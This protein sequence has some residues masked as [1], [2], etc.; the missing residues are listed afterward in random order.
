MCFTNSWILPTFFM[1]TSILKMWRL[2]T[3]GSAGEMSIMGFFGGGQSAKS[4]FSHL[5]TLGR[6]MGYWWQWR[7]K[8]SALS[9]CQK[10]RNTATELFCV[11]CS[12]SCLGIVSNLSAFIPKIIA[13]GECDQLDNTFSWLFLIE[14]NIIY[15][16]TNTAN[17][18]MNFFPQMKGYHFDAAKLL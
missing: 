13:R 10:L 17:K 4:I 12:L 9:E 6:L 16:D 2:M 18:S 1:L 15:N 14:Q 8:M 11:F 5:Y 3:C 7:V